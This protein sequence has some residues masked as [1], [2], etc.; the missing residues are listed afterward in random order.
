ME[1]A[2][3]FPAPASASD[4]RGRDRRSRPTPLL[5]RYALLGG[6]RAGERRDIGSANIYVDRYE[7]A[8]AAVLVA[9]GLLCVLDAFF[10]LLYIQKGGEELNPV[11][12]AVIEWGP[13]PFVAFKCAV[14]DLGLVVLCVHKNF[15]FVKPVIGVLLGIYLALFAYHLYLVAIV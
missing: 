2:L 9:I 6:R 3:A 1:S 5:S 13:T 11:M 15:K 8:L 14:T 10:T 12:A 7:P 4:R